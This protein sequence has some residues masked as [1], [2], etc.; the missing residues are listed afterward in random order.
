MVE[1]GY[2]LTLVLNLSLLL[3]LAS[4]PKIN[5]VSRLSSLGELFTDDQY[6]LA[7]TNCYWIVCGLPWFFLQKNRRG[8]DFPKG[9]H[10]WSVSLHHPLR[11]GLLVLILTDRLETNLDGSEAIPPTPLYIHLSIRVL[12]PRRWI[13]HH[14]IGSRYRPESTD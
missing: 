3:P 9:S 10:W 11:N 2:L 13:E 12:P 1:G 6:V 8:P 14:R 4:N 7:F 5:N